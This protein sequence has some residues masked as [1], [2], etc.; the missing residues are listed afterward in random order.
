MKR[1]APIIRPVIEVNAQPVRHFSGT[2]SP[3]GVVGVERIGVEVFLCI[4]EIPIP[5]QGDEHRDSIKLAEKLA[6]DLVRIFEN[7]NL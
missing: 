7:L 1:K 2:I 6:K 5:R 4:D 3:G